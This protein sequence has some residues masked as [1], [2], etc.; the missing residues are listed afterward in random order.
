M[1]LI[2][3][4]QCFRTGAEI[5]VVANAAA[6]DVDDITIVVEFH[7][8]VPA[9]PAKSDGI[10]LRPP[11]GG[12]PGDNGGPEDLKCL[13]LIVSQPLGRLTRYD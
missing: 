12:I 8:S 10:V 13:F 11:D 9:Y 7:S 3:S 5:V 4:T 6:E 2:F 1:T